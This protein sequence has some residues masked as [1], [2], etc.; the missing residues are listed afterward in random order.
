[1]RQYAIDTV[2]EKFTT[3]MQRISSGSE[4]YEH[5]F[6]KPNLL[7]HS[8]EGA[9]MS[10]SSPKQSSTRQTPPQP[11]AESAS[12]GPLG[13]PRSFQVACQGLVVVGNELRLNRRQ[14]TITTWRG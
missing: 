9:G 7:V 8:S 12:S 13:P 5:E 11:A 3:R 14:S 1:M 10:S 4:N 2:T 6:K